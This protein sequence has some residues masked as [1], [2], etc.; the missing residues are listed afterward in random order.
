MTKYFLSIGEKVSFHDEYIQSDYQV[1]S[2]IDETDASA[3]QDE[4]LDFCEKCSDMTASRG[5]KN[6]GDPMCLWSHQQCFSLLRKAGAYASTCWT[7]SWQ[8]QADK[9]YN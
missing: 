6:F 3:A 5:S 7:K 8:S 2:D 4:C 1:G 9:K